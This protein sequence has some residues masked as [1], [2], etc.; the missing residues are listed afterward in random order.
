MGFMDPVAHN[1]R[2]WDRLA[3]AGSRFIRAEGRLPRT[4]RAMRRMLDRRGHLRGRRLADA[5][6]LVLA[7]GGGLHAVLFAKLGAQTT[8]VD[9]SRR[10]VATVRMLARRARVAIRCVQRD[11]RD[12]A[13]FPDG[14]FDIV[15]HIHSLVYVPDVARVFR[16][17]GRVL[18]PG[19]LYRM[20]TMHPTTLRLYDSYDGRGWRP[21]IS[22]F[23]D[24]PITDA[25]R[26]GKRVVATTLDYAHRIETIVNGLAAAGLV[27]DGLWEYSKP[28]LPYTEGNCDGPLERLFPAYLEVRARKL[29]VT[30]R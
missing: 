5:R 2:A 19:G 20:T 16:E 29:S 3:R 10:Q 21:T 26:V 24:R 6:V 8:L 17:V 27:V 9:F 30:S 25:W 4:H 18:A 12:L 11:M 28:E 14:A 7:G 1:R 15:W 23:A 13:P 22:Y